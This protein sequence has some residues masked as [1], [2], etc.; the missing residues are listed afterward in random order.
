MSLN[1]ETLM[2]WPP[3][4]FLQLNSASYAPS[5]KANSQLF[6]LRQYRFLHLDNLHPNFFNIHMS[7]P[8]PVFKIH[9]LY[10]DFQGLPCMQPPAGINLLGLQTTTDIELRPWVLGHSVWLQILAPLLTGIMRLGKWFNSMCPCTMKIKPISKV[11]LR[12]EKMLCITT[13]VWLCV[14]KTA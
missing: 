5:A 10:K 13:A 7:K 4:K 6:T 14:N 12:T 3:I 2:M 1:L 9:I 11:V 8:Y